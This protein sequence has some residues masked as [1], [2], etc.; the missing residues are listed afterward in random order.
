FVSVWEV[1]TGRLVW[2]LG[3]HT[4]MVYAVAFSPDGRTLATGSTLISLTR[5]PARFGELK[6]WDVA[7]GREQH[8]LR[9]HDQAVR[10]VA[11]SPDGRAVAS[12]GDD[13]VV[14][15]WD[16]ASGR[17]RMAFPAEDA[18]CNGVAFSP[19]GRRLA[20]GSGKAVFVWDVETGAVA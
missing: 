2:K 5:N 14:K 11:F 19:D 4:G 10:Q 17:Q 13:G 20:A 16:P 15:L 3:G 18:D 8:S 7:T 6:I 9:A 1:A 12:A